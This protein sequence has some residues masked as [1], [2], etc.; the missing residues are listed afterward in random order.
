MNRRRLISAAPLAM[1]PTALLATTGPTPRQSTGPFYPDVP[2]PEDD[3]DL[4]RVTGAKAPARGTVLELSGR[5]LDQSGRSIDGAR[6]EI[7]QCDATGRY[8]HPRDR[9]AAQRDPGFQGYGQTRTT[10]SGYR[11]RTIRPVPYPGRTP[12]IH[13]A[14]TA[15]GER[16]F[17]TQMYVHGESGNERDFLYGSIPEELR[18]RVTVMLNPSPTRS[19]EL[20]G[21]F[22]IVLG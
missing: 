18:D 20:A 11:F 16:T 15:P 13:F 7:W 14:V 4:T 5:V 22:D 9:G 17:V 8:H 3:A 19:S 2:P 1:L 12:H 21:V 6:V 10:A